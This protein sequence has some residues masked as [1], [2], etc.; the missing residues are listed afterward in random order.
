MRAPGLASIYERQKVFRFMSPG[1]LGNV[2]VAARPQ[3]SWS[4]NANSVG[5]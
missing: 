1:N 4:R 5:T 2:I 3:Q